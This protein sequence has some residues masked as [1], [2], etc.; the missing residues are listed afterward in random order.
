MCLHE[1]TDS[2]TNV[3]V[4]ENVY[5]YYETKYQGIHWYTMKTNPNFRKKSSESSQVLQ[6]F[7]K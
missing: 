2:S 7:L 6:L 4:S 1:Q 3:Y 5:I